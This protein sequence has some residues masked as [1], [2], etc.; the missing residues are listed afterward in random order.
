MEEFKVLF[1]KLIPLLSNFYIFCPTQLKVFACHVTKLPDEAMFGR[2]SQ[3]NVLDRSVWNVLCQR[4]R[5]IGVLEYDV[6]ALYL[7]IERNARE[8]ENFV[9]GFISKH[10][11]SIRKS[12]AARKRRSG[13]TSLRVQKQWKVRKRSRVCFS[14][15]CLCG[16]PAGLLASHMMAWLPPTA[17]KKPNRTISTFPSIFFS[18]TRNL[19]AEL[20]QRKSG[21]SEIRIMF[22]A[23][24]LEP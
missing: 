20:S 11:S 12:A 15:S 17:P 2:A 14:S 7:M 21:S 18:E 16:D 19:V 13:R 1:Y 4:F 10:F 22:L 5:H 3:N 23:R 8:N 9:F 24:H 6:E